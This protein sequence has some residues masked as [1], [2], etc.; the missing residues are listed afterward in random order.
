MGKKIV[1]VKTEI[2]IVP[3]VDG[4][5]NYVIINTNLKKKFI[6]IFILINK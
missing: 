5:V 4:D 1:F 6:I 2:N 3:I